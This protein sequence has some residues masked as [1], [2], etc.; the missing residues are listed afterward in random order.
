[1]SVNPTIEGNL[2][3]VMGHRDLA[4]MIRPRSTD[5]I[6][7]RGHIAPHHEAEHMTALAASNTRKN[8]LPSGGHPHMT[9]FLDSRGRSIHRL[10]IAPGL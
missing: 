1:M 3:L 7:A 4:A 5:P 10:L 6:R 8:P 9:L 2:L